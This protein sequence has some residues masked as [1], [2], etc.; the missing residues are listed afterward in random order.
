MLASILATNALISSLASILAKS[1][2]TS[3]K[4]RAINISMY[5]SSQHQNLHPF[6]TKNGRLA[7]VVKTKS[8]TEA[9]VAHTPSFKHLM[10]THPGYSGVVDTRRTTFFG[11]SSHLMSGNGAP[12][13][14][15]ASTESGRPPFMYLP[16]EHR[17]CRSER[18][19]KG[20]PVPPM[21]GPEEDTRTR[22]ARPRAVRFTPKSGPNLNRSWVENGQKTGKSPFA[23]ARW[24]V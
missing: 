10:N 22:P 20:V 8:T 19:E 3:T 24:A 11:Q 1:T 4:L 18:L 6:Y 17:R 5:S 7:Q 16:A 13:S 2:R 14:F 9:K 21:S 15:W 12:T 23:P